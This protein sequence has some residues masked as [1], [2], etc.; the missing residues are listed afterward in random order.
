[1]T[2]IRSVATRG[3]RRVANARVLAVDH[4]IAHWSGQFDAVV[5][6]DLGEGSDRPEVVGGQDLRGG[7]H[8]SDGDAVAL[9]PVEQFRHGVPREQIADHRADLAGRD[10]PRAE[11]LELGSCELGGLPQ[12]RSHAAPLPP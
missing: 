4:E 11:T 9:A 8:G 2:A 1:M 3:R 6:D 10:D 5:A 7:M 12:P